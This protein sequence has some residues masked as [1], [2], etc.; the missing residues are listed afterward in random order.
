MFTSIYIYMF[1]FRVSCP[2]ESKWHVHR[3]D[4][5]S[6]YLLDDPAFPG[7]CSILS[8]SFQEYPA[9]RSR[10]A[11]NVKTAADNSESLGF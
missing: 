7:P 2:C 3:N 6:F 9:P 4:I 8:K 5:T 10:T 11:Q 1:R